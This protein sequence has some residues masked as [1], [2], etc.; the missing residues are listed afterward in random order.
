MSSSTEYKIRHK[1]TGLYQESG[2]MCKWSKKGKTWKN[3]AGP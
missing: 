1:L 2:F 3:K